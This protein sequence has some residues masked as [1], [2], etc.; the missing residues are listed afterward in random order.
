MGEF[1]F[2]V[3]EVV[4]LIAGGPDSPE[5]RVVGPGTA[6]G[7]LWC[8]WEFRKFLHGGSFDEKSLVRVRS[9]ATDVF[10]PAQTPISR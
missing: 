7:Q 9:Q 3:N 5:M 8:T 6:S 2:K 10:E 4:R 1:L